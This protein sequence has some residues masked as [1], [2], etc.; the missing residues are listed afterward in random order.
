M[1]LM[2][3]DFGVILTYKLE[4]GIVK[5]VLFESKFIQN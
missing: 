5:L 4:A 1:I 3:F 2:T